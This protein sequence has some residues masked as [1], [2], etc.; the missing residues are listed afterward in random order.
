MT[1]K[2][3]VTG[4]IALFLECKRCFWL[5]VIKGLNRPDS[6]FPS[7]PSGMDRVLKEHFD[8]FARKG[9]L[10]P[11]IKNIDCVVSC[12]LFDN[13]HLLNIWRD[14]RQGLQY[15]DQNSNIVIKAAIDNILK[16]GNK[17]IV[18]DYKTRGHPLRDNTHTYYQTQMDFYNFI[19]RKNGYATED[20]AFLLFYYPKAVNPT[21]EVV[22]DTKLKVIDTSMDA[23]Q[24]I[25][26]DI[27]ITLNG[28]LPPKDKD[29]E[30]CNYSK[31]EFQ[32]DLLGV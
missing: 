14:S 19:L 30:F 28:P 11:E 27:I 4:D 15:K 5:G 23:V 21:G 22:F 2:L 8:R 9:E 13:I 3:S 20:F 17:L 10:P 12:S 29:C 25:I 31:R 1:Y 32:A 24:K 26:S 6:I 18:L 7:L 16:K